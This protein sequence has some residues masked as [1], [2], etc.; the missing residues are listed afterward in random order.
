MTDLHQQPA[1]DLDPALA[2]AVDLARGAVLE[3][4][5][6]DQIGEHLG[7]VA[8]PADATLASHRFACTSKAYV[9]W[10]W[11]VTLAA[12]AGSGTATVCEV[13]LLPGDGAL[14]APAWVPWN[15]RVRPGDLSPGD[16]HPT[17]AEDPR[18]EAGLGGGD[19]LEEVDDPASP[20]GSLRPEQWEIGLGR[21]RVLSVHGRDLAVER[22]YGDRGPSSAMAK[23]A[24]AHCG[25]CGFLMPIGGAVGQVFGVCANPFG[26]DGQVVAFDYGCGAHSSVREIEGTGIPVTE[27]VVDEYGF[28][29]VHA[30][31]LAEPLPDQLVPSQLVIGEEPVDL[32]DAQPDADAAVALAEGE[33]VIDA[34]D[35][36]D[37]AEGTDEAGESIADEDAE[38]AADVD[39]SD[40]E[41]DEH[42]DDD[43]DDDDEDD[44]EESDDEGEP[45]V[46]EFALEE[47]IDTLAEGDSDDDA[48]EDDERPAAP[49]E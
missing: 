42:E 9:G 47:I 5:R 3:V 31:V 36:A 11:S 30:R 19:A 43:S 26:A 16:L 44:D 17:P 46:A 22:W 20:L 41:D 6:E 38:A 10:H 14:L 40:D 37:E 21:E 32:D 24:P 23:A 28:V 7:V 34:A 49:Q 4:A 2:A 39:D 33:L 1:A 29:E 18:L 8:D 35:A 13:V 48:D 45:V 12:A 27:V 25:S 15:E